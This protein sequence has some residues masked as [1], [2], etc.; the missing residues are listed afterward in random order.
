MKRYQ[1]KTRLEI[2]DTGLGGEDLSENKQI[3]E[4]ITER[5]EE[6]KRRSKEDTQKRESISKT[7]TRKLKK[8]EKNNRKI[9]RNKKRQGQDRN[10]TEDKKIVEGVVQKSSVFIRFI[11]EKQ[12]RLRI[13][14]RRLARKKQ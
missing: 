7:K 6:R 5:F 12:A 2:K 10:D 13:Q 11:R 4:H 1:S 9:W 3:L 14:I 8:L